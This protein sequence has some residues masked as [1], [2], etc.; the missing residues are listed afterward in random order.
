MKTI[1]ITVLLLF[2][3]V[4]FAQTNPLA[5]F[6]NLAGSSWVSEGTQLGGFEGKTVY[7]IDYGLDGKIVKVQT[8]ATDPRT[9]EF[10]LRNEGIRAFDSKAGSVVF[11]EFDKLG[12]ITTGKV[13]I[14]RNNFHY[15]YTYQGM[16]LRDS[17]IY[18]SKDEYEFIVGV[19][20]NGDW[21]QKFHETTL[22]RE[23]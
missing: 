9:K 15:T 23:Q 18:K 5:G 1:L 13:E 17:W 12:G 3:S 20:K 10:G 6:E 2:G 7:K 4:C 16:E 21:V 19:W 8:F 11:Y 14:E 22:K